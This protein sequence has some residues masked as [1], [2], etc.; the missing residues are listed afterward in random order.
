MRQKMVKCEITLPIT[1]HRQSIKN[2]SFSA[3]RKAL[4][5]VYK[6]LAKQLYSCTI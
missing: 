6:K 3:R 4:A 2:Q 5:A 1:T